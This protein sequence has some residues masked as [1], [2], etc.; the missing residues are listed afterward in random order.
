MSA[1]HSI[2]LLSM[3]VCVAIGGDGGGGWGREGGWIAWL[4][5]VGVGPALVL[6][7]MHAHSLVMLAIQGRVA[8]LAATC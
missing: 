7:W 6:R 2:T 3:Q 8:C 1:M 5:V 4:G